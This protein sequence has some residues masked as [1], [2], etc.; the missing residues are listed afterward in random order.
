M[1]Y[2]FRCHVLAC[3]LLKAKHLFILEIDGGSANVHFLCLTPTDTKISC[4]CVSVASHQ[5]KLIAAVEDRI[6]T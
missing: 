2:K 4:H 3:F 1:I 6:L 5:E